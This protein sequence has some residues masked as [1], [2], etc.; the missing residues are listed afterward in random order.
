MDVLDATGENIVV[1]SGTLLDE[2][3]V[4]VLDENSVDQVLV[5]SIITC[6]NRHGV[7][8]ACY[9]RDLGRGHLVNVGEAVGRYCRAIHW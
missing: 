3:W 9:G 8:V 4:S 6:E 1:P 7:C 2:H 5:R